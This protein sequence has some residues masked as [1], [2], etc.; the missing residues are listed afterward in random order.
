[1]AVISVGVGGRP[2]SPVSGRG[3]V[4]TSSV[5]SQGGAG[6]RGVVAG[7]SSLEEPSEG[8]A[9]QARS[10]PRRRVGRNGGVALLRV[11]VA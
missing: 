2:T 11:T 7:D 8:L 5:A 6:C 9:S 3:R 1:M 4:R 10:P